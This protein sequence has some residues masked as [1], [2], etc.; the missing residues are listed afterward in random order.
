MNSKNRQGVSSVLERAGACQASRCGGA[1][2][3][4]KLGCGR[5]LAEK[6]IISARAVAASTID[7]ARPN[8]TRLDGCEHLKTE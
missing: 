4:M 2:A 1:C 6:I 3:N 8:A 7:F 5:L